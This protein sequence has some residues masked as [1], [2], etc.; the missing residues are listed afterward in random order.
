MI[1]AIVEKHGRLDGVVQQRR[2]LAVRAGRRCLGQ[3]RAQDH[4]TEP[5]GPA[6]RRTRRARRDGRAGRGGA[7]VN[8]SS[9]SGHRPSPGTSAYGASK[10][11]LDNLTESLAVEWAPTVR[12]NSVVCGPIE[13]E[14]SHLHYGDADGVAAVRA[15]IPMGR[16]A[17]P[18]DV[19]ECGRL[20]AVSARGLHHRFDADPARWR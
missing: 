12:L 14:L 7:I 11:G 18:A 15:T 19:G 3:L 5:G 6:R 13:T 1:A 20:P 8:V 2:W 17:S 9:V 16:L 4:R 10:A